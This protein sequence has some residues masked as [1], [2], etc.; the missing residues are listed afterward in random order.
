MSRSMEETLSVEDIDTDGEPEVPGRPRRLRLTILYAGVFPYFTASL[1][2]ETDFITSLQFNYL[3]GA[4]SLSD[5]AKPD[6]TA[7][8]TAWSER[9]HLRLYF[10][11]LLRALEVWT[12]FFGFRINSSIYARVPSIGNAGKDLEAVLKLFGF[13]HEQRL[14]SFGPDRL[15]FFEMV[16]TT[17]AI[18]RTQK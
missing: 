5:Y 13:R 7:L 18:L 2:N 1:Y 16:T 4:V 9:R 8:P 12:T 6:A 14:R 3:D 10:L 15:D 17:D 11:L